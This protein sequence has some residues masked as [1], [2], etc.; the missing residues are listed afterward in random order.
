MKDF[1][2]LLGHLLTTIGKLLRPGGAR[3]VAAE[4]A[5]LRQQILAIKQSRLPPQA[6][7]IL[8]GRVI[9]TEATIG[10][11]KKCVLIYLYRP[12]SKEKGAVPELL[13]GQLLVPPMMTNNLGW[14]KG[15]FEFVEHRE[16]SPLDLLPQ[17][18][19]KDSDGRYFDEKSNRLR[20]PVEPV[21]QWG[22]H[23]FRA[24]DDEI[25]KAMGIALVP[26]ERADLA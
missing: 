2:I 5:L 17:H 24:I 15:Y 14:T 18:C 22:L 7:D 20:A 13:R 19:F 4:N 10:P 23:S 6:G 26:D 3:I 21:G 16:L 11:M 1:F 25:L 9:S 8:Y 12:R